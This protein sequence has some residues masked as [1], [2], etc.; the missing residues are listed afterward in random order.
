MASIV[1]PV[2]GFIPLDVMYYNIILL[3]GPVFGVYLLLFQAKRQR[4]REAYRNSGVEVLGMITWWPSD[5][6]N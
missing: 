4:L 3:S 1:H 5:G 6:G 2:T